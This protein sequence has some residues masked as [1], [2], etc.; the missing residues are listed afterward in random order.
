MNVTWKSTGGLIGTGILLMLS[1][2]STSMALDGKAIIDK[3][4]VQCHEVDKAGP[5]TLEA[6]WARKGPN[7]SYAGNKYK[8]AWLERWLTAPKRIRPAGMFYANHIEPGDTRDQVIESSLVQHVVLEKEEAKAVA[9]TLMNLKSKSEL[10][11]V[12]AY[13]PGTISLSMGDLLFVK[14]RGCS[15][16]HRIQEDYGGVSGPEVYTAAERLQE[17]YV[18]SF[19]RDPQAWSPF[20]FMPQYRLKESDIQ[21]FVHYFRAMSGETK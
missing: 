15:S 7:L 10:I 9:K 3:Q 4:C 11:E 2:T 14:F 18:V 21:K 8:Q 5:E 16:C 13:K 20:N 19:L 12:G 1:L 17:D 6:F